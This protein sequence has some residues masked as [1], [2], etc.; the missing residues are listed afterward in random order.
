MQPAAPVTYGSGFNGPL[1]RS[2]GHMAAWGE[3]ISEKSGRRAMR[4]A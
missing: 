4:E 1:S 3:G 2:R